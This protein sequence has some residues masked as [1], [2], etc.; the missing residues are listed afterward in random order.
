[1][2]HM[3]GGE[4]EAFPEVVAM[5]ATSHITLPSLEPPGSLAPSIQRAPL[6][7]KLPG[8]DRA[9]SLQG[10]AVFGRV[11]DD[12][13]TSLSWLQNPGVLTTMCNALT[14]SPHRL[15]PMG[16][17][18]TARRGSH[19][20]I[21]DEN[22][23]SLASDGQQFKVPRKGTA[24]SAEKMLNV[25]LSVRNKRYNGEDAHKPPLSFACMIFMALESSPT[26]TLPVKQ[27][28]E[29]VQWKF[30]YYQTATPGWKNSIRHNLSL[31]KCFKKVEKFSKKVIERKS[32]SNTYQLKAKF[33][34]MQLVVPLKIIILSKQ[35]YM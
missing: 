11:E 33:Q 27:I 15:S 21:D 19:S 20:K 32:T 3:V 26:K 24:N 30:P 13:L 5:L 10:Q 2:S 14:G 28:Y 17:R 7:G 35:R 29:W 34:Y 31:N 23:Y 12:E 6:P 25:V 4:D 18:S 1:M 9:S 8:S 16:T 22:R